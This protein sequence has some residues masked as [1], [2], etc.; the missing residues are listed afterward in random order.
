MVLT[1]L[2]FGICEILKNEILTIFFFENF[3]FTIAPYGETKNLN[4]ELN[5]DPP[6]V[7]R[8]YMCISRT[9]ANGQVSCPNRAILKILSHISETTACTAKIRSISTPWSK[10]RS[11]NHDSRRPIAMEETLH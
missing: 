3:K 11:N 8:E 10:N 2:R 1:K 7:E 5:F 6:G 4:Y 9:L